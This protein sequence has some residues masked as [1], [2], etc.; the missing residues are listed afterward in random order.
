MPVHPRAKRAV[1]INITRKRAVKQIER[2][3]L[4]SAI[5][6]MTAM[7]ILLSI[8]RRTLAKGQFKLSAD[9]ANKALKCQIAINAAERKAPRTVLEPKAQAKGKK[10]EAAEAAEAVLS[11]G[12]S[13]WS[14]LLNPSSGRVN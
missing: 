7:Q 1:G 11:D 14:D 3:K 5:E 2:A 8:A 9:A 4:P 13:D 10:I 6:N 12:I